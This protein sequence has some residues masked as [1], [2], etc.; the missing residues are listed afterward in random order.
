MTRPILL[1]LL[2]LGGWTTIRAAVSLDPIQLQLVALEDS[3]SYFVYR[4]TA[5]NPATSTQGVAAIRLDV[6]ATVGTAGEALP[7]TGY[8]FNGPAVVSSVPVTPHAPIGPI[9]P[10]NWEAY[11]ERTAVLMWNGANGD[12]YDNDSIPPAGSLMGLGVRSPY[13]PGIRQVGGVPT[14]QSCCMT[15]WGTEEENPLRMLPDREDFMVSSYALGPQFTPNEITIS[16]LQNQLNAICSDPLWL[17][18]SMLCSEFSNLLFDAQTS[19]IMGDAYGAAAKLAEL[20]DRVDAEQVQMEP[21]AYWLLYHNVRQSYWNVAPPLKVECTPSTVERALAVNCTPTPPPG[22]PFEITGWSFVGGAN[23]EYQVTSGAQPPATWDGSMVVGG[24]VSVYANVDSMADT[25]STTVQVTPRGWPSI[26]MA[27]PVPEQD[28]FVLGDIATVPTSQDDLAHYHSVLWTGLT[29]ADSAARFVTVA[30]GPNAT[31]TY[32]SDPLI[33]EYRPF[34]EINR[35]ALTNDQNPWYQNHPRN[36]RNTDSEGNLICL[37]R[38][39]SRDVLD[40]FVDRMSAEVTEVQT[41]WPQTTLQ[42][43][44]ESTVA[45]SD[46]A[47]EVALS[48][49]IDAVTAQV[50]SVRQELGPAVPPCALLY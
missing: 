22:V 29:A 1:G 48:A 6:S 45:V 49:A 37:Q 9:S 2:V 19:F 39:L 34:T 3:S 14:W 21:E 41:Y 46:S 26:A 24:T 8:F 28:Q 35:D 36:G 18:N 7:A 43:A 20:R 25:A 23:S 40:F 13:L 44:I 11:L 27:D 50:D 4:Y 32:F 47:Q 31:L 16:L 42:S 17:N 12:M 33:Q 38:E 15:P 30:T 5:Q 10:A